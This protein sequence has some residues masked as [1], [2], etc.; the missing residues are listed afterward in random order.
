MNQAAKFTKR[1][2]SINFMPAFNCAKNRIQTPFLTCLLHVTLLSFCILVIPA[3][4]HFLQYSILALAL[5]PLLMLFCLSFEVLIFCFMPVFSAYSHHLG[6]WSILPPRSFP[7]NLIYSSLNFPLVQVTHHDYMC[8]L[9]F[10]LLQ[11][12]LRSVTIAA[13]EALLTIVFPM[14]NTGLSLCSPSHFK[15]NEWTFGS[16][17]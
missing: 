15:I 12:S 4:F 8:W 7:D 2:S 1:K 5:G 3:S 17:C 9:I 13:L 6:L 10:T 11:W 16:L 14:C